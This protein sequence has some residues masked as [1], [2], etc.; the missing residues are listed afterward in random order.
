MLISKEKSAAMRDIGK[1]L[2]TA[3]AALAL[4]WAGVAF[5]QARPAGTAKQDVPLKIKELSKV[6]SQCLVPT[7]VFDGRVK[8]PGRNSGSKKRWASLEVEYATR[9]EWIDFATFT[10]HVMCCDEEGTLHY[11][12]TTVTYVDIA[13]GEHGACV[14]LPPTTVQRCGVPLAFG[15]EIEVEDKAVGFDSVGQFKGQQWWKGLDSTKKKIV[16]H[17]EGLVDR[18]KT[19]FG[20]THIDEYEAVR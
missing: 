20:L 9:P 16:R 1:F 4:A 11:F 3:V 12:T 13:K 15:V 2:T 6:G 8:G 10:F 5:G 17:S 19:P 7:P 18:S 14:M